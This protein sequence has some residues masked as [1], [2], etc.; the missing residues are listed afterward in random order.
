MLTI[1]DTFSRFSPALEPRFTFCGADVVECWKESGEIGFPQTIRV[2]QG[3]EFV[4]RD[5]D[6]WA[7]CAA[8]RS[9][10][11]GPESRP[12]TPSSKPSTVASVPNAERPLV[13]DAL[14]MPE[15]RLEDWR[16]YYNEER[17]HGAIGKKPPITLLNPGDASSP[18]L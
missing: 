2:D 7:Y 8:S 16:K 17:P 5:L 15:K 13:P 9:T 14:Q 11:R 3:T 4:S 10:S 6:L 12:T 18:P 1:V